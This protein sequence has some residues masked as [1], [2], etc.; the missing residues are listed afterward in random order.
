MENTLEESHLNEKRLISFPRALVL[1]ILIFLSNLLIFILIRDNLEISRTI[2]DLVPT[3]INLIATVSLTYAA[4]SS[5]KLWKAVW[6]PW[7]ILAIAQLS[8]TLGDTLWAITELV[9]H[10]SPFPSPADGLYLAFYPLFALGILLLPAKSMTSGEKI[11]IFLD[12]GI[13][14]IASVLAFWALLI[15]PTIASNEGA[16]LLTVVLAVTYPVMDLLL[17]FTL[18]VVLF[19]G[20]NRAGIGPMV[21]LTA[22]MVL[23]IFL[24]IAFM[25][26]SLQREYSSGGLLDLGW[27]AS[28]ILIGLAGVLQANSRQTAFL[29]RDLESRYV[30]FT[31]PLYI[32]Y[33]LAGAV[34]TLLIYSHNHP[35]PI[36]FSTMA[37][38]V[39]CIIGLVIIRQIVALN[40]NIRLYGITVREISERKAIE[41]KIR[42][43]NEEL[44][45][46]VIERTS[47]LDAT[48]KRLQK[49]IQERKKTERDLQ[50]AK[51]AAEAADRAKSEFL[52]VMSH[53]IR[54]PMNAVIGLTGLLLDMDLSSE[55]KEY[56]EIIRS[57]GDTLMAVIND[58]L[59]FSKIESGK[60]ELE[61]HPFDLKECIEECIGL[62]VTKAKDKDLKLSCSIS[63]ATPKAIVGDPTRLRQV[64]VNLLGNA[65]KFTEKGEVAISIESQEVKNGMWPKAAGNTARGAAE[66]PVDGA[67]GMTPE[68]AKGCRYILYF[69]VKDT[70]I[71]IPKDRMDKL[72]Q[73]FTQVDMSTTRKYGGTGLGLAISKRLV[74]LMGG[75]IWAESEVGIGSTFNFYLPVE[76]SPLP[77]IEQKEVSVQPQPKSCLSSSIRILLA[78]DNPVNQKVVVQMLKKLGYRADV[79]DDG[80]DALRALEHQAYDIIFMDIQMPEMDGFEAARKIK[81]RGS[82]SPLIIALTACAL[83]GDRDR[84]FRAGMDGYISK[85]VKPESLREVIRDCEDR[86][87]SQAGCNSGKEESEGTAAPVN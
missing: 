24:D 87:A 80:K 56:I 82:E 10:Q 47:Q 34:F 52:A 49:E 1:G 72:F 5:K 23:V 7:I 37:L 70:G 14:M 38:G 68:T 22:A 61:S 36:T 35:F 26:Q 8:Y 75:K 4:Y 54:T 51:E 29:S 12:T 11:K 77:L 86:I 53:E 6:P 21:L 66:G 30:Q 19:R 41:E 28:Y 67:L 78:E 39:G 65:I 81:E 43:L 48:N 44:E 50:R 71:G 55:Q 58:I 32:P 18:T 62:V 73:S 31:W 60:M 27:Y 45:S 13:V 2:S 33:I 74:E 85:P 79:A 42:R 63:E 3:I 40:E 64:L 57:S 16:D 17:I 69:S 83:E 15:A 76:A 84:C 20:H 9:Y 25:R 46:R 59:D